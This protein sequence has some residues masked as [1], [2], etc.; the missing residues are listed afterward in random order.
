MA[1]KSSKK[2]PARKGVSSVR[3]RVQKVSIGGSSVTKRQKA[4]K[5]AG[6]R[7]LA[8]FLN[9]VGSLIPTMVGA[10]RTVGSKIMGM[11]DYEISQN[12]II[13]AAAAPPAM[14]SS[15]EKMVLRHREYITDI[16]SSTA[17]FTLQTFAV[18]PGLASTFPYL[19]SIAQNF[20]E[21]RF[22]GLGFEFVSEAADA[23]S[24]STNIAMGYLALAAQYRADAP[25]WLNKTQFMNEMWAT[26]KRPN[27]NNLM[28]I[29][30]S[31][32]EQPMAI[33]YVRSG[34]LTS[35]QDQK[36]YDLCT[37]GVATGGSPSASKVG[38]L[39]ATYEIELYK[40]A[41][42]NNP[43]TIASYAAYTASGVANSTPLGTAFTKLFDTVGAVL[44]TNSITL[45]A[46][47]TG[48]FLIYVLYLSGANVSVTYP[49]LT[50]T[51]CTYVTTAGNNVLTS[52][53]ASVTAA[54]F[55]Q[56]FVV[57]VTNPSIAAVV[58]FGSSGT[59]ASSTS[60]SIV[61]VAQIDGNLIST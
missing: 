46:G 33:Q 14:H 48:N 2:S 4:G 24:S 44:G 37:L 52:P 51:N 40:P 58:T 36:F 11:G 17:A 25:T 35:G 13:G 47:S 22:R 59:I 21:Y 38:E 16:T 5:K 42:T 12:S 43:D 26:S 60:T 30:C 41:L 18:N 56:E 9:N 19:S 54:T 53:A 57:N 1:K 34:P 27:D 23:F 39:W 20:Q 45:P 3:G 7:K 10:A 6:G 15:M 49:A 8:G 32:L 28:L 31:P 29:E 61:N 50:L 55:S